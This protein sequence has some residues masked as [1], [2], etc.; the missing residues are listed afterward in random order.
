MLGRT[1]GLSRMG[2][3]KAGR[4]RNVRRGLALVV[5]LVVWLSISGLGPLVHGTRHA[6]HIHSLKPVDGVLVIEEIGSN[7]RI[8]MVSVQISDAEVVRVWRDPH[9]PWTWR[10]RRV[11]LHE[12][13]AGTFVV[14]IGREDPWGRL[15]ADRVEIPEIESDQLR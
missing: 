13:P 9:R 4:C 14:V 11:R 10:E 1:G 6:G 12:F 5:T 3:W 8:E 15:H 7:G 2:R